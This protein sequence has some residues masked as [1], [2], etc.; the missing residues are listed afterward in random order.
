MIELLGYIGAGL[1]GLALGM[2]GGGGAI[3]TVP[4]L[5]VAFRLGGAEATL[6]SLFVVGA[7]ASAVLPSYW[8]R[9]AVDARVALGFVPSSLAGTLAA[10]HALMPL[11]PAEVALPYGQLITRDRLILLAFSLVMLMAARSMLRRTDPVPAATT[12]SR[13]RTAMLG[14]GV[15]TVTGVTGAGGGFLIVPALTGGLGLEM[16]RAVG[17]SLLIIAINTGGGFASE[18]LAGVQVRWSLLVAFTAIAAAGA[19]TGAFVARR[20]S[21]RVLRRGFGW[22]T[23]A[24]AL[25]MAAL[26]L[27]SP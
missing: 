24:V 10:R 6:S 26:Q 16:G 22:L 19:R 20:L 1:M 25:A 27:R 3:L 23:L 7:T 12:P 14:L 9:G 17:T 18:L 11:I 2:V 5:V 15:G 13:L 21:G 4:L 8:Q